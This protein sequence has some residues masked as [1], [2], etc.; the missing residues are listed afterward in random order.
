MFIVIATSHIIQELLGGQ[1]AIR[2]I[3]IMFYIANEAL[4]IVENAA[5]FIP[6][7]EKLRQVLLQL[8]ETEDLEEK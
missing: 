3:V 2:E 1:V 4:S 6:I 7:P 5:I 8:R